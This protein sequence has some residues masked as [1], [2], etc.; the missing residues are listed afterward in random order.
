VAMQGVRGTALRTQSANNLRQIGLAVQQFAADRDGK[1]PSY[2]GYSAGPNPHHSL[3]VAVLPYIDQ[4]ARYRAMLDSEKIGPMN[5]F[6]PQYVSPADPTVRDEDRMHGPASY[7]A[8]VWAFDRGMKLSA[9]FPDGTS[10]TLAFTEHYHRC[11]PQK[12]QFMYMRAGMLPG[13]AR[14]ATFADPDQG[15][16]KPVTKGSPSVTGP[17]FVTM[18]PVATFQIAPTQNACLQIVPQTPHREGML[19]ALMDGSV[20][21][22]SPA[23]RSQVY[24]AAVTPSG[25]EVLT[26]W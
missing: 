23:I 20:R 19:A 10:N 3:F 14:A 26:D 11:G 24:W 2:D 17:S 22:L 1:L 21:T 15:D 7:G 8:N 12:M 5:A 4:G 9:P 16:P 25:G 6:V 13:G 18:P